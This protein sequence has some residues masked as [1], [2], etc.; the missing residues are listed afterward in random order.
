MSGVSEGIQIAVVVA[1]FAV[2]TPLIGLIVSNCQ[3]TKDR[4][5]QVRQQ[6]F[7]NYH[8]LVRDLVERRE[9]QEV[10]R[11]DSQIA[12]VYELRNYREYREVSIRILEG[13]KSYWVDNSDNARLAKL[14]R[15]IKE[16][17]YTLGDLRKNASVRR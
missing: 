13:L 12:V 9:D 1:L 7:V 10:I 8:N 4:R 14:D 2:I 17:D 15:L 16:V 5:N 3:Y 11:L 6:R